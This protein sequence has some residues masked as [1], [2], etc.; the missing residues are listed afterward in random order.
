MRPLPNPPPLR[1]RGS[2][3]SSAKRGRVGEGAPTHRQIQEQHR[4]IR[5]PGQP[6]VMRVTDRTR[7]RSQPWR[8]ERMIDT[9]AVAA[10][11]V[12]GILAPVRIA[13]PPQ[14][15]K[16][17][18]STLSMKCA[19]ASIA[20][21]SSTYARQVLKSPIASVSSSTRAA[22]DATSACQYGTL[23][24]RLGIY[25][26]VSRTAPRSTSTSRYGSGT[27]A[28][29]APCVANPRRDA[30]STPVRCGGGT[31]SVTWRYPA[32]RSA[33][34]SRSAESPPRYSDRISTSAS[35][36]A[37]AA[38]MPMS[39]DPPPCRMFQA[40][41]RTSAGDVLALES[42]APALHIAARW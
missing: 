36:R 30:T 6:F 39:R 7:T 17:T 34:R 32:T 25:T 37:N 19:V 18:S 15:A 31:S 13:V 12:P 41:S 40:S 4:M 1:G 5:Q 10:V 2:A 28:Q 21:G 20:P 9:E 33:A 27:A 8:Q 35:C 42:V 14:V 38:M 29:S 3:P 22:N 16:H 23:A 11:A 26:P 24:F